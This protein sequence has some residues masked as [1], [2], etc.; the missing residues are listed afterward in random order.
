MDRVESTQKKKVNE[1]DAC[2]YV[3]EDQTY[4]CWTASPEYSFVIQFNPD[5]LSESKVIKMA[6]SVPVPEE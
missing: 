2:L 6:E 4:L 1:Y 3:I 5:L